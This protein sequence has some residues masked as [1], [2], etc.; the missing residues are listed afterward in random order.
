MSLL[1]NPAFWV[2][3]IAVYLL[4]L[5]KLPASLTFRFGLFNLFALIIL[6]GWKTALG[7]LVFVFLLWVALSLITDQKT[8][9][10]SNGS[11]LM[12]LG[13]Y[14]I[15][16]FSFLLHK[17]NLGGTAFLA[18]IKQIAP[19]FPA[20]FLLP[21]FAAVSFSYIFVR[22]IDLAR[23]CIWENTLLIDPISLIGY[24]IPFHMLLAGPVNI[25][26]EHIE[27]TNRDLDSLTPSNVIL[28]I[29][30][31]TTGLFYKFALAEGIRI[32]FYGFG[33]NILVS[34]W[35]DPIILLVY[36]FFDFA[37]YSKIARGLGLLYGIPT[38]VNFN[39]PFLATSITEF[40]TRW[41]MSMG[42]FVL[43][44]LFIPIQLQLV[45]RLGLK[46]AA[47][48]SIISLV[49]SFG[50]V[51][52]WHNF[53]WTWFLWGVVMGVLMAAEKFMQI[54]LKNKKW[55][56][57]GHIKTVIDTFGRIYVVCVMS[58]SCYFVSNEIFPT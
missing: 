19:W 42:K 48:A 13:F 5:I 14:G 47:P 18:Q 11:S 54:F 33:G 22:C 27:A 9:Q 38:P 12:I 31:I 23:S 7:L 55:N 28:I 17:L 8:R 30:E 58:L 37:G 44:N 4:L 56:Q 52:L 50:F 49:I 46:W 15:L 51:G 16:F 53:S 40:F 43:R 20:E 26:K 6:L 2:M 45:R 35:F 36:I 24:L 3:A 21:F 32:Y 10:T 57:S 1:I 29:N 34:E 25:Y 39:A 41:H